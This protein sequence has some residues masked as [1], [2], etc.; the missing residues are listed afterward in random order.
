M[1]LSE[2]LLDVVNILHFQHTKP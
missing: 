1:Y 2:M